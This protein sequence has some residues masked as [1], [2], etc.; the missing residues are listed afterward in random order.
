[1]H[2]F[3]KMDDMDQLTSEECARLPEA[4]VEKSYANT[5]DL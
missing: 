4:A 3:R 1:M 5:E 2:H